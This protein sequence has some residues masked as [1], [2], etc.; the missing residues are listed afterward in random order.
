MSKFFLNS[1]FAMYISNIFSVLD[2][3]SVNDTAIELDRHYKPLLST[4]IRLNMIYMY[5][6]THIIFWSYFMLHG[7]TIVQLLDCKPLQSIYCGQR[8]TSIIIFVCFL[9]INNGYFLLGV[10]ND[11][12]VLINN[13]FN[14]FFLLVIQMVGSYS[15]YL[16]VY[17]I[18]GILYY[19]K[20]GI[21]QLLTQLNRNVIK[22]VQAQQFT[23]QEFKN[24]F[25]KIRFLSLLSKNLN[26]M[27][28]VP[29]LTFY[30][31]LYLSYL[32]HEQQNELSK[33]FYFLQNNYC[34]PMQDLPI[35]SINTKQTNNTRI[36]LQE[37]K[38]YIPY[39]Q[40]QLFQI[41]TNYN[42]QLIG[43]N[44]ILVHNQDIELALAQ[45]TFVGGFQALLEVK[46]HASEPFAKWHVMLRRIL[47]KN[48]LANNEY[49][50][51][52]VVG[53]RVTKFKSVDE[54]VLKLL[55]KI[56]KSISKP[57]AAL[58][59]NDDKGYIIPNDSV[60]SF[61]THILQ[62]TLGY[63]LVKWIPKYVL[64]CFVGQFDT[65]G[66]VL[67]PYFVND[68]AIE[69]DRHYKPLLSTAV[70]F[71][72]IYMYSSTHIIYWLHFIF[73]GRTI[74]QLLDCKSLQ[75]IYCVQAQQFT[76]QELKN[77]FEKIRFLSF[78]S[79]DLNR[80]LS[81][82]CLTFYIILYLSY[83]DHEQQNELS[84]MFYFLQNNYCQPMQDLPILSINTKQTSNIRIAL[85]ELKL[86]I[87]YFQL[88]LFRICTVNYSFVLS[89]TLF[90]FNMAVLAIQTSKQTCLIT[91]ERSFLEERGSEEDS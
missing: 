7:R 40:L 56:Q 22:Q 29:C 77:L 91:L 54:A 81:G 43:L 59:C 25:E 41:C 5:S 62:C 78:L 76:A 39:F 85:Q 2:P 42:S 60:N 13:E 36:A 38:L 61:S 67:D 50:C 69:L 12:V 64:H 90:T 75:S 82:P 63:I 20:Y 6:S 31:I 17:I 24:L 53:S 30:I 66:S 37:L 58:A 72:M 86:Y 70:R 10:A 84:K 27:L 26:R 14:S 87:P 1:H 19:S 46:H 44:N 68:T 3:Y 83:L 9:L 79:K 18:Y 34:Q 49:V 48:R 51:Y 33:M 88:Q 80:M 73:Y 52:D 45:K 21:L 65:F 16:D 4:V 28:S 11:I 35:L 74:F 57:L 15:L 32:D 71:N 55:E 8:K 89:C 47:K 23:A